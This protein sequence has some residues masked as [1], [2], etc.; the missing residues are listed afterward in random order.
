MQTKL[1]NYQTESRKTYHNGVEIKG[2]HSDIVYPALG[3]A[4]ETGELLGKIKKV[5]RDKNGEIDNET[6]LALKDELGDVLWYFTQ[7][8]T[9]L[10]LDIDLVAERNLE[11]LQDREKRGVIK[12]NGDNR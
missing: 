6:L 2:K 12:G 3:L 10:G 11:K 4:N 8:C 7:I 1:G 9:N 5:F